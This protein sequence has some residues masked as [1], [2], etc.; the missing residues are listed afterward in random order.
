MRGP[1]PRFAALEAG[2]GTSLRAAVWPAPAGA[3]RGSVVLL[4]GRAECV[5]KYGETAGDLRARGFAVFSF[6]WRG[7]GGSG[8]ALADPRKG[9]VGRYEDYLADLDRFLER[10]VLPAAPRPIVVLAH[11][12]GAH[13]ALRHCAAHFSGFAAPRAAPWFADR[14]VLAA[15]LIA[16]ALGPAQRVLA[17]ALAGGAAALGLGA[18]AVP[19]GA[20]YPP[21]FDGNPLTRDRRRFARNEA[22]LRDNPALAVG[23]PTLGWLAATMR[24]AAVLRRAG[25]A[26]AVRLPVLIV[27]AGAD[28]VV[29]NAAQARLA[30][31]L[32]DC[33]FATIPDARHELLMETDSVRAAFFARFDAFVGAAPAARSGL[34]SVDRAGPYSN[35]ASFNCQ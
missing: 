8:R 13:V 4:Q 31:R 21:A 23:W 20:G 14:L 30:A 34:Q 6:D 11:S 24:S 9:H 16:L 27:A 26:E 12:M 7:Q 29:S 1:A 35:R 18:R 5:E 33:A 25:F 19:G 17:G 10:S 28:R 32:P 15:P 2:D 22:L 3:T